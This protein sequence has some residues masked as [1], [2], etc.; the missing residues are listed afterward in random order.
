MA[1]NNNGVGWLLLGGFLILAAAKNGNGGPP[2][3][4]PKS[5]ISNVTGSF[6]QGQ[7]AGDKLPG[8][9]VDIDRVEFDYR[10]PPDG[11]TM[12]VAWKPRSCPG[13]L[14]G[15]GFDNGRNVAVGG[16]NY[17]LFK[18]FVIDPGQP[19]FTHYNIAINDSLP[20]PPPRGNIN[21]NGENI[22]FAVGE[23]EAWIGF[24]SAIVRNALDLGNSDAGIFDERSHVPIDGSGVARV[25]AFNL[26]PEVFPDP[27]GQNLEVFF[28]Q[29]RPAGGLAIREVN[30]W[31]TIGTNTALP[32]TRI[33]VRQTR[34]LHGMAIPESR[35]WPMSGPNT[36]LPGVTIRVRQPRHARRALV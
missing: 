22:S 9:D 23:V 15:C 28:S 16:A 1:N 24:S 7:K 3:G 18:P 34:P 36:S 13:V 4:G 8:S 21:R 31:P 10:G 19:T 12:F 27:R 26:L 5:T 32:G 25:P 29:T 11:L 30:Q 35:S 17:F 6:G 33:K 2:G 20:A 14:P